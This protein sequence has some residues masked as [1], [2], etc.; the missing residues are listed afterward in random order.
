MTAHGRS[1]QVRK[2]QRMGRRCRQIIEAAPLLGEP[3]MLLHDATRSGRVALARAARQLERNGL[4][5]SE[6]TVE[7]WNLPAGVEPGVVRTR[8]WLT[9]EGVAARA[10]MRPRKGAA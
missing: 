3:G 9:A 8:V 5:R 6:T 7:R 1:E 4:V 2:Q 10:S